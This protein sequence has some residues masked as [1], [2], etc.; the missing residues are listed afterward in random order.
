MVTAGSA[1]GFLKTG[2]Y[3]DYR[4]RGG[5]AW[6]SFNTGLLYNQWLGTA[7]QAMGIPR[8][9]Y[10]K[11]GERGYGA[12]HK[13]SVYGDPDTLWPDRLKQQAGEV[14]PFLKA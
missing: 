5:P 12:F 3:V 10:E 13:E 2:N 1:A 11:N 4:R 7:L 6:S 14:L 8:E 9:E